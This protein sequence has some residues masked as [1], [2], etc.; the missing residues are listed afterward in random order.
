MAEEGGPMTDDNFLVL[1]GDRHHYGVNKVIALLH[2][3]QAV[4]THVDAAAA[5]TALATC[6]DYLDAVE[7]ERK[8]RK[9]PI[10]EQAK[11]VD[12]WA[13]DLSSLVVGEK[14]KVEEALHAYHSRIA[15]EERAA[16]IAA[17]EA[18][19]AAADAAVDAVIGAKNVAPEERERLEAE[20]TAAAMRE[21]NARIALKQ[22]TTIKV[23]TA[24]GETSRLTQKITV[25]EIDRDAIDLEVL[26]PYLKLSALEDA[27]LA[28]CKAGRKSIRG[29]TLTH[30]DTIAI[31]R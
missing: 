21:S 31:R 10:L 9:A 25:E 17:A 14:A 6:R 2:E 23:R 13:E 27:I 11:A 16:R 12:R 28:A 19:Q 22:G 24:T 8:K 1:A 7:V 20:A 3:A 18:A 29:V 26:R 5:T 4:A 30:T 15:A